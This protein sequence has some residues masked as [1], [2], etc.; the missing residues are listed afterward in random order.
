MTFASPDDVIRR[1]D[2]QNYLLD[3]GTASAIYLAVT[4]G[5]PLLLEGEP[6]VGKTTAAKTL[7]VVLDTTLIRLQCYE[8]LTANEALYDWNYQRQLLSI[9]LAE[10]R[11][12]GISDISEADLYTEAYLVDRPILRCVRHRGPTPPVLLIDEIDRA[13]DE[14]E[15]LLLEFLGE[16]AV[17]VPELGTFLAE[18]PPMAVLTSNRSR[19][20]HDALRRRCL[21]HW[22]DYPEPDRAAAIVRRT[23]PGATAP[24]IEN[25]TQFVCTARDLD[26]DKPPGVAETIDWVAALVALGVADLTAADSSPALASLGALAKTPDDRTQIRDAYQ[27]FTECSHA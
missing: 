18:C 4:L 25:A 16:S 24:L 13:D 19:D 20:L 21:Y 22:I 10:A 23:V 6:G 12:K 8:G 2:E 17:T 7:A 3:T 9:R 5:R 15:A 26:L 1:F 14:F 27:A 11:G